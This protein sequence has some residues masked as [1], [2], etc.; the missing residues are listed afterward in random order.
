MILPFRELDLAG[1]RRRALVRVIAFANQGMLTRFVCAA[2][3][4][5][6][7]SAVSF[8]LE[9][10]PSGSYTATM[11]GIC[12]QYATA[13]AQPGMPATLMFE[14]C[15]SER[16]CRISSGSAGYQCEPPGPMIIKPGA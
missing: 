10:S 14:Q 15:M 9:P 7:A 2:I 11:E 8:A 16:H 12:R 13:T 6:C 3:I 1:G 4:S 5:V